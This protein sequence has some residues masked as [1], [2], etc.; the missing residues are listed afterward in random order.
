MVPVV[1]SM[2]VK[3][4]STVLSIV[5]VIKQNSLS[6]VDIDNITYQGTDMIKSIPQ[7]V[8]LLV[9]LMIGEEFTFSIYGLFQKNRETEQMS[10][11]GVHSHFK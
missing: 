3:V 5:I 8:S 6:P 1:T 7:V 9:K 10:N 4:I 2:E 11:E